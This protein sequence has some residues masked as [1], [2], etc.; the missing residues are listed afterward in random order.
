[1]SAA[2]FRLAELSGDLGRLGRCLDP[3]SSAYWIWQRCCDHILSLDLMLHPSAAEVAAYTYPGDPAA[4]QEAVR[5]T[6]ERH[7]R[8]ARTLGKERRK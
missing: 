7:D 3:E 6:D 5:L 1:V 2:L 4:V 8:L